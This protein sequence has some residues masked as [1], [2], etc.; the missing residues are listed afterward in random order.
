MA[1]PESHSEGE[2]HPRGTVAV[3]VIFAV[4]L[5]VLW[6]SIY[7]ILVSQGATMP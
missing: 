4:T 6:G 7:L 2:F 1:G 3:L 5:A